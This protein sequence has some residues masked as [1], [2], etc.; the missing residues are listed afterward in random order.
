MYRDPSLHQTQV[1]MSLWTWLGESRRTIKDSEKIKIPPSVRL[2]FGE[3][4]RQAEQICFQCTVGS[5]PHSYPL[6]LHPWVKLRMSILFLVPTYSQDAA[7][8]KSL[9]WFGWWW[10]GRWDLPELLC[11]IFS[12]SHNGEEADRGSQLGQVSRAAKRDSETMFLQCWLDSRTRA[13]W[14][15]P[16]PT[17]H[18][19]GQGGDISPPLLQGPVAVWQQ[20]SEQECDSWYPTC[21]SGFTVRRGDCNPLLKVPV[22]KGFMKARH[23]VAL[24]NVYCYSGRVLSGV[25]IFCPIWAPS[26]EA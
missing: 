9:A 7:K 26:R 20:L 11:M 2:L 5:W 25:I 15:L 6:Y 22:K 16:L 14:A 8:A 4:L 17:Q 1:C 23:S 18:W 10:R 19:R 13:K 21:Q 24:V 12:V 3:P